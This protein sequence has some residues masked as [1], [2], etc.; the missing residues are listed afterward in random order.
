MYSSKESEKRQKYNN[1]FK[2]IHSQKFINATDLLHG[3]L[4]KKKD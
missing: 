1:H 4:Q 2:S 3:R